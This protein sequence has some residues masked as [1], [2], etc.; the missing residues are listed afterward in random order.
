MYQYMKNYLSNRSI[1]TRV[2]NQYSSFKNTNIGIP[3]G[4]IIAPLLFSILIHDLPSVI[5]KQFNIVQYADD[6]CIWL[7]TNLRKH[8]KTRKIQ[9]I[10]K[11]YQQEL[12]KVCIYMKENGFEMSTEKTHLMLFNNGSNCKILPKIKLNETELLYKQETK[13]LGVIF[14]TKLNWKPH[15]EY[16]INKARKRLNF[17]KVISSYVWGQHTPTL[18]HL[19]IS[20]IRSKLIYGQEVYFAAPKYLLKKL[21]S[22]DSK[23]IKIA[24]GVPYHANTMKCYNESKILSL[25]KQRE[26]AISKYVSRSLSVDNSN[27]FEILMDSDVEYPKFSRHVTYLT[28]I[29]NYVRPIMD[30]CEVKLNDIPILPACPNVPPWE[31][32]EASYEIDYASCSKNDNANIVAIDAKILLAE[33]FNFF[34]KV[35]TDGSVTESGYSGFGF[36]IPAL[37]IKSSYHLGKGFSIFTSELFAILMALHSIYTTKYDLHEILVC[38]DSLSVLQTLQKWDC[39]YRSDL[40]FEIK[41]MVHILALKGVHITFFWIP[42]HVN[43]KGNEMADQLA[44]IGAIKGKDAVSI[45]NFKAS[46]KEICSILKHHAKQE[47]KDYERGFVPVDQTRKISNIVYRLRLNSWATKYTKNIHCICS[48]EN[49]ITVQHI[50][51]ECPLL[52]ELYKQNNISINENMNVNNLLL[53]EDLIKYIEVLMHTE[54]GRLL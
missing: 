51:C 9:Y 37:N 54:I 3:Q 31:H 15:I 49:F 42:S 19:A 1:C 33:K 28:P 7:K 32:N 2:N 34:L 43:I 52:K 8:T 24:L 48:Q 44:K 11:L 16:L 5:S 20:L 27:R 38:V 53:N 26:L 39:N 47:L 36:Y 18:I 29:Y 23:A 4:S 30:A 21:Q 35:Y 45:S 10:Q 46:S 41:F 13:F 14:D 25:E 12:D 40:I 22:I 17:L 50:L 6:I